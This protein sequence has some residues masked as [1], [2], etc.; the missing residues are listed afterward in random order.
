VNYLSIL[1]KHGMLTIR[2]EVSGA[3]VDAIL[4]TRAPI[5]ISLKFFNKLKKQNL[6][7]CDYHNPAIISGCGNKT[8]PSAWVH[9]NFKI[10]EENINDF[11][12]RLIND[13]QFDFII[14]A[15]LIAVTGIVLI[16][17]QGKYCLLEGV[18]DSH[19]HL[20][21][22]ANAAYNYEELKNFSGKQHEKYVFSFEFNS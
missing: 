3:F 5:L 2:K 15:D 14:G 13:L 1:V 4:D 9:L 22:H 11:P 16:I 12:V 19:P 10:P 20:E 6:I 17:Y 8:I 21:H 18:E 7:I